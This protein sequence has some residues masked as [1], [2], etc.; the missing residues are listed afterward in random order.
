MKGALLG[1]PDVSIARNVLVLLGHW[2]QVDLS[3]AVEDDLCNLPIE[4]IN[5]RSQPLL[6]F[7]S[8]E[9]TS[10]RPLLESLRDQIVSKAFELLIIQLD[11]IVVGVEDHAV[12]DDLDFF[13]TNVVLS[14]GELLDSEVLPQSGADLGCSF[15]AYPAIIE[16]ELNKSLA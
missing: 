3:S 9:L 12:L 10:K 5:R 7:L 6:K 15:I 13:V 1:E 4:L 8:N 14:N 16:V 11:R 2:L